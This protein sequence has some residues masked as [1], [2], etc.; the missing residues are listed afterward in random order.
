MAWTDPRTWVSGEVV[1]AALMN[2][3][4]RD[5]FK[6]LG[7]AWQAYTP[8]YTNFTL[9]NGTVS[10]AYMQVGKMAGYRGLVTLG[11]T[12]SVSGIFRVSL[13]VAHV[14]SA[15]YYPLG[16]NAGLFDTS[17]NARRWWTPVSFTGTEFI[18]SDSSAANANATNPWTWA[19]GDQFSWLFFYE[20]A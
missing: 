12:S 20:T 17:A 16:G 11:S 13:P 8:T 7:D 2:A 19:T 6:A 3:H 15:A 4:V 10:A 18:I 5:N 9:G 14:S 1:T